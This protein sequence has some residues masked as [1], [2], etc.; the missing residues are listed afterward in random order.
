MG[1]DEGTNKLVTGSC[2]QKFSN[3]RNA[4][5]MIVRIS[6]SGVHLALHAQM[7]VD[8]HAQVFHKRRGSDR[9]VTDVQGRRY[10]F[11]FSGA[12]RGSNED[13][14]LAGVQLE[15]VSNHP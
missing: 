4:T 3:A 12:G 8:N 14:R 10:W 13:V 15:F 11:G 7:R 6:A 1:D 9:F 2:V 5:K